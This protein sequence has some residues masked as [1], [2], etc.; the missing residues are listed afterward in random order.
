MRSWLARVSLLGRFTAM[1]LVVVA[2]L[3]LAL[4]R[5]IERRGMER[6]V[7]HAEVMSQIGVQHHLRGG[8]LRYPISLERV[9]DLDDRVGT[10]FFADSR[11]VRVK[12]F[13]RDGRLV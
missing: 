2:A 12:L 9:D 8:D 11:I 1:G 4:K 7:D 6:A 13:N 10:R 5:Q 3:G